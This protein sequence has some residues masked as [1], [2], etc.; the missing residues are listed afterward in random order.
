MVL[1]ASVTDALAGSKIFYFLLRILSRRVPAPEK[2]MS[3]KAPEHARMFL[4]LLKA[5]TRKCFCEWGEIKGV[6]VQE[7]FPAGRR[8]SDTLRSLS[9]VILPRKRGSAKKLTEKMSFVRVC[10]LLLS[11]VGL[12]PRYKF[13]ELSRKSCRS[14]FTRRQASHTLLEDPL[15]VRSELERSSNYRR[16]DHKV[17]PKNSPAGPVGDC[18]LAG[19]F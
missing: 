6:R 10:A 4:C 18:P 7:K 12:N 19:F 5:P 16:S 15:E 11:P 3:P 14:S 17:N 1:D 2:E 8:A 13:L 9:C